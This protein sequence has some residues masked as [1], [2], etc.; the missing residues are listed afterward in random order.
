MPRL[1]DQTGSQQAVRYYYYSNAS[2]FAKDCTLAQR[3]R[4]NGLFHSIRRNDYYLGHGS[5]VRDIATTIRVNMYDVTRAS[6]TYGFAHVLLAYAS[7][8]PTLDSWQGYERAISD[9]KSRRNQ[10]Y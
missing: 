9:F 5:R 10:D 2:H 8:F 6:Y 4:D 1:S 3:D 7:Q